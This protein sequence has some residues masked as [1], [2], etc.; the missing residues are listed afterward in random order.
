LADFVLQKFHAFSLLTKQAEEQLVQ[1]ARR[2]FD[3]H[4]DQLERQTAK[5]SWG[6][7]TLLLQQHS[8]LRAQK[9]RLSQAARMNIK[10][11]NTHLKHLERVLAVADPVH[12]LRRGFSIVRVAGKSVH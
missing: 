12:L 6:V 10:S 4:H 3:E 5:I 2:I 7:K 1:S 8:E 9:N 11:E